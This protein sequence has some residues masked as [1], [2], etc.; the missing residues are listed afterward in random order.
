[1]AAQ[2]FCDEDP[3]KPDTMSQENWVKQEKRI[4]RKKD[5]LRN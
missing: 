5:L 2:V 3:S 4:A 1:M